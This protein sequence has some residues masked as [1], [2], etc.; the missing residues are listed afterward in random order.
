MFISG[1]MTFFMLERD[2]F[3]VSCLKISVL[4]L[5]FLSAVQY[6]LEATN[7]FA[8][9]INRFTETAFTKIHIWFFSCYC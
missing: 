5:D 2:F 4:P 7:S 9:F 1:F 3:S 8:S 6:K